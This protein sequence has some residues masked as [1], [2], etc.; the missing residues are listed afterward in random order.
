MLFGYYTFTTLVTA[1]NSVHV[2]F[3]RR[4]RRR[5][6]FLRGG[7]NPLRVCVVRCSTRKTCETSLP[8]L[9]SD[10]LRSLST[11]RPTVNTE[12]LFKV[13]K[14]TDDF[15]MEGWETELLPHHWSPPEGSNRSQQPPHHPVDLQL[16]SR[17]L[18]DLTDTTAKE[19]LCFILLIISLVLFI[20]FILKS[21]QD[22]DQK[23]E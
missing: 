12:D 19:I 4:R 9:Q 20:L 10:M 3:P 2:G 23:Q 7:P 16:G 6:V 5:S 8:L 17:P 21:L 13:K 1:N 11:T 15:G 22:V 14:F 18:V